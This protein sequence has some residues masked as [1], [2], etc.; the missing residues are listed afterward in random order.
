MGRL[1]PVGYGEEQKA[2]RFMGS[3]QL[4]PQARKG[5]KHLRNK[6]FFL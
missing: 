3:A 4:M 5:G 6:K 2:A 1:T